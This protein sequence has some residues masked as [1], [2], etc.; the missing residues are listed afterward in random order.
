MVFK[1]SLDLI[2]LVACVKPNR[3]TLVFRKGSDEDISFCPHVDNNQC[4]SVQSINFKDQFIYSC[5]LY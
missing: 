3:T 1:V 5:L 4:E 2:K